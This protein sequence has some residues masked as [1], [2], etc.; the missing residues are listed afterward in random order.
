[1]RPPQMATQRRVSGSPS[2]LGQRMERVKVSRVRGG[3]RSAKAPRPPRTASPP[4][5]EG[6]VMANDV[7][8]RPCRG[9]GSDAVAPCGAVLHQ[10]IRA[11]R[12]EGHHRGGGGRRRACIPSA[13]ATVQARHHPP[14]GRGHKRG[15]GGRV[16]AGRQAPT[17][18][19]G[20]RPSAA[21]GHSPTHE[22][23]EGGD[24]GRRAGAA[25]REEARCFG[26]GDQGQ[27]VSVQGCRRGG[28]LNGDG[29]GR[30]QLCRRRSKGNRGYA[31]DVTAGQLDRN[32][33]ALTCAGL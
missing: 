15:H 31:W 28:R 8:P 21:A 1:M 19:R 18:R 7:A 13:S 32:T 29:G 24:G 9:R 17:H 14:C 16:A 12:G 23:D 26:G 4:C 20:R 33:N 10:R 2:R 22:G 3:A 25:G 6:V 30:I 27:G 11:R 5:V